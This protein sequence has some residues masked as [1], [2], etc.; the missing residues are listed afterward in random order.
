MQQGSPRSARSGCQKHSDIFVVLVSNYS[1][2]ELSCRILGYVLRLGAAFSF[3]DVEDLENHYN[4]EIVTREAKLEALN[5]QLDKVKLKGDE[6]PLMCAC[7]SGHGAITL[8]LLD[9]GADP[10]AVIMHGKTIGLSALARCAFSFLF[11]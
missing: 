9:A 5:E 11:Y 1:V 6:T 8:A 7:R 10:L 4:E 2:W 3:P